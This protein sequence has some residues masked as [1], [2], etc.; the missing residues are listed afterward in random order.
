MNL[1][2]PLSVP[3]ADEGPSQQFL[4]RSS[5]MQL[6]VEVQENVHV[7]LASTSGLDAVYKPSFMHCI[8]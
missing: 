1:M 8:C 5:C 6:Q 4:I 7:F 3:A 2:Q